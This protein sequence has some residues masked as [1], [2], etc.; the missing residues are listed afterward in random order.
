MIIMDEIRS[1]LS[2]AVCRTTNNGHVNEN[3]EKLQHLIYLA[4]RVICADADLHIDGAVESFYAAVFKGEEIHRINHMAGGQELHVKWADDAP[5]VHKIQQ[6]LHDGKR[7]GVCCG[8]AQELKMLERVAL[9]IVVKDEVGIYYANSPKQAEIA[10]V[11]AYWPK[12]K[13]VGF[14]STITVSV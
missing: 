12:Y 3:M 13:L 1:T 10:D 2:S 8:S 6:D 11:S 7:I 9:E 4:D 14:T 5:F